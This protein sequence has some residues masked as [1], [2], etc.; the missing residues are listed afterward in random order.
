MASRRTLFTVPYPAKLTPATILREA[1]TL[2]DHGG[3]D[4]LAMRPLADALGVRPGSLYRHFDS[5]AALLNQLA[6]HA[7]DALRDD[8]T[9]AAHAQ[10]PRA[11]LDAIA[12]AYL[13]FAHT[14]P[15]TYDLLMTP[16]PEQPPGIKTTAGKHLWNALLAHVGALSGNP[17]D[18]GH[19]VAYWT[20]LHGAASLQRS[21]L[22]GASG[23]Q[24]GLDIGLN[25]ILDRMERAAH[26]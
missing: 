16:R 21:G 12:R 19:A 9:A 7:A 17:D 25:A 18:T 13:H 3:P 26:P 24:D 2:L 1:Q 4:A 22:Y 6:E 5:R 8:V 11:A 15:H 23:P 14:R 20:F 10:T